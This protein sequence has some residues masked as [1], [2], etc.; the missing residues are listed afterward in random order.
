MAF[1]CTEDTLDDLLREALTAIQSQGRANV[2][3]RGANHELIGAQLELRAPRA[4]LSRTESRGRIISALGELVWY[5]SGSNDVEQIAHYIPLYRKDAKD[6]VVYGGYGP[7]LFNHRG[8]DQVKNVLHLLRENPSTRRAVIQL[9]SAEDVATRYLEVPCT[10]TLQFLLRDKRLHL[11]VGMRSNDAFIGLPHDVFCFT[12][13]QEIF[14]RTL[15]V[16]L[17]S[18]LHFV[19]SFH[20]YDS[21]A[22]KVSEFLQ[23]GWQIEMPMPVMPLGDPWP[24]VRRLVELES[25]IRLDGDLSTSALDGLN[26]YWVDLVRLLLVL[27]YSRARRVDDLVRIH[28]DIG[29]VFKPIVQARL[30]QIT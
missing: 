18:Y 30:E 22:E 10:C 23:E 3:S 20:R 28:S 21:D 26:P 2:A 14:A 1:S 17:G 15:G 16:E 9:F 8:V 19:G 12:M 5:L 13:L 27:A 7:R 6:G 25:Q 11:V 24:A 29:E 4:R